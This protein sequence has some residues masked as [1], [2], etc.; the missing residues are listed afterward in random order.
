MDSF[1]KHKNMN[2]SFNVI[3]NYTMKNIWINIKVLMT[4]KIGFD[5][6]LA[7]K[8]SNMPPSGLAL[9]N[10]KACYILK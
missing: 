1:D 3:W 4:L 2:L 9:I 8:D 6:K 5:I 10:S 7:L